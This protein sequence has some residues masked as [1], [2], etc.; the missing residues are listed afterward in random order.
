MLKHKIVLVMVLGMLA[1]GSS[2]MAQTESNRIAYGSFVAGEIA[3]NG[4]INV[5]EF[6]GMAGDVVMIDLQS[7][8]F[9]PVLELFFEDELIYSDDD[10]GYYSNAY[11]IT[12]PLEA[13]G[14]YQVFVKSAFASD[15]GDYY[16][17]LDG[18]QPSSVDSGLVPNTTTLAVMSE[19]NVDTWPL[20]LDADATLYLSVISPRQDLLV[21][22]TTADGEPI[23]QDDDSGGSLNPLL[24]DLE[25]PAGAYR[26]V[27]EPA[28]SS[29]ASGSLY[30]V[31]IFTSANVDSV[32][33]NT[34][35]RGVLVSGGD[36]PTWTFEADG[37][38]AISILARSEFFDTVLTVID[39]SGTVIATDDD[40]ATD[41]QAAYLELTLDEAGTYQIVVSSFADDSTGSY[42]LRVLSQ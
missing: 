26:V 28:T 16:L 10:S 6:E 24:P 1:W 13:D 27:V 33:A 3:D 41:F 8:T 4:G 32:A 34:I 23:A 30:L 29:D 12:E 39:P 25:L 5:W 2:V 17:W 37:G 18:G 21:T 35:T 14:I 15:G 7:D 42:E 31:G 38:E 11:L 9:D 40:S 22:V 20:V 36:T 19:E